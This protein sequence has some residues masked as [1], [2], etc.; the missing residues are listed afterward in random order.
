MIQSDRPLSLIVGGH[1]SPLIS[2][3]LS[4][5]KKVTFAELPGDD[6]FPTGTGP[7][8]LVKG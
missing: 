7:K 8:V 6:Y 5:S 2:G 1:D 3:H 4:I